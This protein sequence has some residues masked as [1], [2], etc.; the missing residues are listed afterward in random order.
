M[1]I[2]KV[3]FILNQ[4]CANELKKKLIMNSRIAIFNEARGRSI[5]F[6][7]FFNRETILNYLIDMDNVSSIDKAK[8]LY[9]HLYFNG[10]PS[11]HFK[12]LRQDKRYKNIVKHKNYTLELLNSYLNHMF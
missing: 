12:E 5:E 10:I 3:N 1:K 11:P 4:I 6:N 8:I 7:K 9:S 2:R